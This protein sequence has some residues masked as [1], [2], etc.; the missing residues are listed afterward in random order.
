[1]VRA[2]AG[3]RTG[4]S[5][6]RIFEHKHEACSEENVLSTLIKRD[7]RELVIQ[8]QDYGKGIP[9]ENLATVEASDGYSGLGI[10]GIRESM[11][12]VGGSLE[13]NSSSQGTVVTARYPVGRNAIAA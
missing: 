9:A 1:M 13:I 5:S 3:A 4:A 7:A 11:R 6:N 12:L 2:K 10:P 8:V